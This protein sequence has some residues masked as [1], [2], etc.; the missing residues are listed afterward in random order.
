VSFSNKEFVMDLNVVLEKEIEKRVNEYK[1]K[2]TE[3]AKT[4]KDLTQEVNRLKAR[5]G[6]LPN[7][8]KKLVTIDTIHYLVSFQPTFH[9]YIENNSQ[10]MRDAP[11]WFKFLVEYWDNRDALLDFFE[12]FGIEFASWA[13]SMKMPHEWNEVEL[14]HFL[15]HLSK[16]YVC[17]GCIFENNLGWWYKEQTSY[18]TKNNFTDPMKMIEHGSYS[19]IPWQFVMKNPLWTSEIIFNELV[20]AV[21][22]GREHSN[23][24]LKIV[25]YHKLDR[26][27][28]KRLVKACIIAAKK[29]NYD[30]L[31]NFI[32]SNVHL[33]QINKNEKEFLEYLTVN[34]PHPNSCSVV[35]EYYVDKLPDFVSRVSYI[36]NCN[37]LNKKEKADLVKKYVLERYGSAI[38][39]KEM[40]EE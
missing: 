29:V 13:R 38:M 8:A 18:S 17:N 40:L 7:N 36:E 30:S 27:Q 37:K 14:L 21:E 10:G 9:G 15:K 2:N 35:H 3:L 32:S 19:E 22:T 31:K 28:L 24:L 39:A 4:I 6:S 16:Q 20:K 23:Y 34:A 33:I 11:K 26:D 25:D 1:T 12:F 5:S